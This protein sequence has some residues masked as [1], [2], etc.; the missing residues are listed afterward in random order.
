LEQICFKGQQCTYIGSILDF[1][2]LKDL[3][4][5]DYLKK[6]NNFQKYRNTK[7]PQI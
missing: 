5:K 6:T 1:H 7:I 2:H 4:V 3:N